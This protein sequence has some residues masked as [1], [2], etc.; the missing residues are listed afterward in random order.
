M[1][2]LNKVFLM[3]YLGQAPEERRSS[4]GSP[5]TVLNLATHHKSYKKDDHPEA[6]KTSWF[7]V[8]VWGKQAE[9]CTRYLNKGQGVFV[10]G[11]L[12]PYKTKTE[13]GD[14][15]YGMGINAS[16]IEFLPRAINERESMDGGM[17]PRTP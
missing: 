17:N 5:Y 13:D 7:Q 6:I 9:T 12:N 2:G 16:K 14:D 10:E 11:Y 15:R 8:S 4:T 1:H 3:G